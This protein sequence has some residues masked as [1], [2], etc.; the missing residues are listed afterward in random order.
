MTKLRL[1]NM[2]RQTPGQASLKRLTKPRKK[3]SE[4]LRRNKFLAVLFIFVVSAAS[5]MSAVHTVKEGDSYWT[6]ARKYKV[7]PYALAYFNKNLGTRPLQIGTKVS[8]P[9]KNYRVPAHYALVIKTCAAV[10]SQPAIGAKKIGSLGNGDQVY[11]A[12]IAKGWCKVKLSSGESG[13]MASELLAPGKK[14]TVAKKTY[15]AKSIKIG[16]VKSGGRYRQVLTVN[17]TR[18]SNPRPEAQLD[19]SAYEDG[20]IKTAYAYHGTRYRFGG[21]SRGGFDCS[22]FTR[23]VYQKHGV[24]L[25]HN[26]RAQACIGRKVSRGEL[27][28][29]DLVFFH[30]TR[31]GISHVGIYAGNGKFIHAS[32]SGRGVRVDSLESGY[33]NKRFV[34]ARRVK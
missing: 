10:R 22:G 14:I 25:P 21:T 18:R 4:D 15:P 3:G 34:G 30:T 11:V 17:G 2:M 33:Y 1:F 29:G 6:I 26:S 5:A 20:V 28:K 16:A 8:I 31:P 24:R 9:S 13:W 7:S 27:R 23:Y 32:S 19:S 12:A